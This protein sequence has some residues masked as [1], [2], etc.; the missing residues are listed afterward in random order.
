VLDPLEEC[1]GNSLGGAT[2]QS[3]GFTSGTLAC[4]GACTLDTSGCE[5]A[6]EGSPCT[7]DNDCPANFA[8]VDD[9][10]FDGNE[11]DPCVFD[12][13]CAGDNYCDSDLCWDGSVGDSCISD[14]DCMSDNCLIQQ[15]IC[16][17]G[18][19]GDPCTFSNECQNSCSNNVC[20]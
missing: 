3:E 15:K 16:S 8:C 5:S 11:G 12:S 10:C 7:F 4:S 2:C 6:G 14:G 13:D 17:D 19:P 1:D 18:N 20:T 9:L